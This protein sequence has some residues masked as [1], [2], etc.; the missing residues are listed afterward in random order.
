MVK[1]LTEKSIEELKVGIRRC[2][3]CGKTEKSR[4]IL[5]IHIDTGCE[6]LSPI[7]CDVCPTVARDYSNF[8]VYFMEHQMGGT[9]KCAICLRESIG[10]MRQ[11]LVLQGHF[12]PKISE[13]DLQLNEL[14]VVSQNR[15]EAAP[16]IH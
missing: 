15:S 6:E 1:K 4:L 2:S 14:L 10:D 16:Q 13:L 3:T 5:D 7:E 9:M 11:H 12:L 8:V